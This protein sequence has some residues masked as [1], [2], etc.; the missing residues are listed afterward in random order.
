MIVHGNGFAA[1]HL[2]SVLE[3]PHQFLLFGVHADNGPCTLGKRLA[4]PLEVTELTVALRTLRARKAF[5][6]S[7]QSVAQLI[8]QTPDGVG[9][10]R[11]AQAGQLVAD[12]LQVL[13]GPKAPPSHRVTRRVLAE[14]LPQ[15]A[16][17]L[18]RFFSAPGRPPPARRTRSRSTWPPNNSCRPRAT[19]PT[20][21]PNN[22]AIR[23]SPPWPHSRL[24]SPA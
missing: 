12:L 10:G 14:Q 16:Q 20:S 9:T 6:V 23:R 7:V 24:S 22:S 3:R 1:P 2:A 19:V 15:R 4:L 11:K 21:K 13:A 5:A 18:R 8:E 17:D